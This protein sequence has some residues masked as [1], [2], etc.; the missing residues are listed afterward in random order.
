MVVGEDRGVEKWDLKGNDGK[1]G[2]EG[3]ED[4]FTD[5]NNKSYIYVKLN[6]TNLPI[7]DDIH[8]RKNNSLINQSNR[9]HLDEKGY[10]KLSEIINEFSF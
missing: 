3:F 8:F 4:H 5:I 2:K 6:N 7:L 1:N 9:G 10:K